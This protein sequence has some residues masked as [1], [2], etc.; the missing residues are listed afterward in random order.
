[1]TQPTKKLED[2]GLN[3]WDIRG[4]ESFMILGH[5]NWSLFCNHAII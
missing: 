5:F 3:K 2:V 4:Q 1:M